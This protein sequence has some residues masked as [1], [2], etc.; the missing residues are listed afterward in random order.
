MKA[1]TLRSDGKYERVQPKP[2]APLVRS[3]ARFIEMTRDRVKPAEA[4]AASSRFSLGALARP[5]VDTHLTERRRPRR[6]PRETK[7]VQ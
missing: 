1:W 7:K 6:E 2:G 3:Q 5:K 4:A